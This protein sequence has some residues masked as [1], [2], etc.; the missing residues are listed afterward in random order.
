MMHTNTRGRKNL[1]FVLASVV[2]PI[3]N[4]KQQHIIKKP[5]IFYILD[6]DLEIS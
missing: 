2:K 5:N 3:M 1:V 4:L 6:D